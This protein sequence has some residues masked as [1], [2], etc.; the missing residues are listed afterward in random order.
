MYSTARLLC[1]YSQQ[2]P[3]FYDPLV[4]S[5][6]IWLNNLHSFA[7]PSPRLVPHA[8]C[9]VPGPVICPR[10]RSRLG[11]VSLVDRMIHSPHSRLLGPSQLISMAIKML[12]L[13]VCLRLGVDWQAFCLPLPLFNFFPLNLR[14]NISNNFLSSTSCKLSGVFLGDGWLPW[15]MVR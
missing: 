15:V 10:S 7:L 14:I 1:F 3:H 9:L 5:I 4:W 8:S 13:N 12:L 11:V 6:K 2:I